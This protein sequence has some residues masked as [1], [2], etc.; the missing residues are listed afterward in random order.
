MKETREGKGGCLCVGAS[1]LGDVVKHLADG[2]GLLHQRLGPLL[3]PLREDIDFSKPLLHHAHSRRLN[4]D[5]IPF[6][7][8]AL[9]AFLP[10]PRVDLAVRHIGVNRHD[11]E[12]LAFGAV[13]LDGPLEL[14][15][16]VA[17]R[18]VGQRE[19]DEDH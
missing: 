2:L 18:E 14:E 13:L 19:A 12:R 10:V 8:G 1:G 17:A 6:R 11:P 7:V 16:A 4:L 15:E 5:R 3:E 9:H